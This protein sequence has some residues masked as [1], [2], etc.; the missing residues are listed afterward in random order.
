MQICSDNHEEICYE[1]NRYGC[2]ICILL[3]EKDDEIN[4][5]NDKITDLEN[6][7]NSLKDDISYL[8]E[9]IGELYDRLKDY[10][11]FISPKNTKYDK[12]G[13]TIRLIE[14]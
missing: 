12:I 5:L 7:K 13:C 4:H 11:F 14:I 9:Q 10:S 8:N 3:K 6:E 1:N 2:P